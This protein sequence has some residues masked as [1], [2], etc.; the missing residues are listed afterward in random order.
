MLRWLALVF[1][2]LLTPLLAARGDGPASKRRSLEKTEGAVAGL[3]I[4][5]DGKSVVTL[6]R[7]AEKK[8]VGGN[9]V[10][11]HKGE[12]SQAW[13]AATGKR[14][15]GTTTAG[16]PIAFSPDGKTVAAV[17]G[18]EVV[19]M[20]SG[21]GEVERTL[22]AGG[23]AGQVAVVGF[24]RDGKV[25]VSRGQEGEE[26]SVRLWDVA[27]GKETRTL[28][29]GTGR[30]GSFSLSA[31][32]TLLLV[33]TKD[34]PGLDKMT[35]WDLKTGKAR[36]SFKASFNS[37]LS[38]AVL[39]PDGATVA[40]NDNGELRTWNAKTGKPGKRVKV[41]F[42][43][44]TFSNDG[45]LAFGRSG[46]SEI[47]FFDPRTGKARFSVD[48]GFKSTASSALSADGKVLAVAG[49]EVNDPRTV[50]IWDLGTGK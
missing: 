35:M 8:T 33:K 49:G 5:P 25:L 40:C 7:I 45:K 27:S 3:L 17:R 11:V 42:L 1:L 41:K 14:L 19:L 24:S 32:G 48:T 39:S 30:V 10:T 38:S 16:A 22:K 4:S 44:L 34:T 20:N 37:F 29:V 15:W 6:F 26:H 50:Q 18:G 43:G 9:T 47:T 23:P 12:E 2:L 36:N 31:D 46:A 13:D 28:A 21:T